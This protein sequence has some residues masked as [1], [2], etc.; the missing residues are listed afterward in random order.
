MDLPDA[1]SVPLSVKLAGLW[2]ANKP[3]CIFLII[4]AVLLVL[5]IIFVIVWFAIIVPKRNAQNNETAKIETVS[6][7]A[8]TGPTSSTPSGTTSTSTSGTSSGTGTGT[9]GTTG[10][11][12]GTTAASH[13]LKLR[14]HQ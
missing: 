8:I 7:V 5:G 9:T 10:T 2:A 4:L 14:H 12:T 11:A 13:F 1:P 6:T 3:L